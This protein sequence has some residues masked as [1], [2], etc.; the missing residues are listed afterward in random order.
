M[1]T[2]MA[3]LYLFCVVGLCLANNLTVL[4][5]QLGDT[6]TI[7]CPYQRH[8]DRWRKK[9]WC[10][11]DEDGICHLVV[12]TYPFWRPFGKHTSNTAISDHTGAGTVKVNVTLLQKEDAGIY[13]CQS[14][15]AD[16]VSILQR[17]LVVL[18]DPKL[19]N[20][21][22]LDNVNYSTSR[23]PTGSQIHL[24]LVILGSS[25]LLVKLMLMGLM[26]SWW[27][28]QHSAGA[29]HKSPLI[30]TSEESIPHEVMNSI[31]QP[32]EVSEYTD[33]TYSTTPLYT[34]YVCMAQHINKTYSQR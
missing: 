12:R 9:L 32:E 11:E 3:I 24:T 30:S 27:R 23:F 4:S 19:L 16:K 26:C 1:D 33:N 13:Q 2:S 5:G 6:L 7:D 29:D 34:N 25:I 17:V 22:E 18:K 15:S 31:V 8:S 28:R 20:I 10:K 21:S 14:V